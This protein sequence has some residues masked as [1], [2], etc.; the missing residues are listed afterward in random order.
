MR[1]NLYHPAVCFGKLCCTWFE[2]LH[3]TSVH[4]SGDVVA[5]YPKTTVSADMKGVVTAVQDKHVTVLLDN[6]LTLT[7]LVVEASDLSDLLG[8]E[9]TVGQS[10]NGAIFL[11]RTDRGSL[12]TEKRNPS[13][14]GQRRSLRMLPFCILESDA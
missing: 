14:T 1:T 10:S 5:A 2:R 8:C 4:A 9:V 11:T 13:Y 6:G 12:K 7:D 3:H